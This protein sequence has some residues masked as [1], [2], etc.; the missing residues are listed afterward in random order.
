[1]EPYRDA[2]VLSPTHGQIAERAYELFLARGRVHGYEREDW[3][4]AEKQLT[5]LPVRNTETP[6]I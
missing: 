3:L 2:R 6:G 4:E 5:E 1:L